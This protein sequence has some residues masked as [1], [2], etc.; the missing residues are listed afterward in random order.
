MGAD[1]HGKVSGHVAIS[2]AT[3]LVGTI[4]WFGF[5]PMSVLSEFQG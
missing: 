4:G 1:A 5:G 2:L 3:I